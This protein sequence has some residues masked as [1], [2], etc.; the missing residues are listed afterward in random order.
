MKIELNEFL[1]PGKKEDECECKQTLRSRIS[2]LLTWAHGVKEMTTSKFY[3]Y[4]FSNIFIITGF[5][6]SS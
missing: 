1:F 4:I 3:I 6:M 5:N 2:E